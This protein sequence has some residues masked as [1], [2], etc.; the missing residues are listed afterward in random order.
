M[1]NIF[2]YSIDPKDI[3]KAFSNIPLG[4]D[5]TFNNRRLG[6]GFGVS[7]IFYFLI[8]FF[9]PRPAPVGEYQLTE[10]SYFDQ[11]YPPKAQP[12]IPKAGIFQPV[13]L[14]QEKSLAPIDL[15]RRMEKSQASINLDRY[16]KAPTG[17]TEVIKVGRKTGLSTEE[18]LAQAPIELRRAA[19]GGKGQLGLVGYPGMGAGVPL[20]LSS[21]GPPLPR[22]APQV[23]G[24]KA[25]PTIAPTPSKEQAKMKMGANLKKHLIRSSIV[26]PEF[27]NWARKRGLTNV[28]IR[29][30]LYVAAS[31]NIRATIVE[32]SS[33]FPQ[34]DKAVQRTVKRWRCE[35]TVA[36]WNDWVEFL[37]ILR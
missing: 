33:G 24:K 4:L 7:F 16:S 27:P 32:T 17:L 3:P 18:I 2:H 5:N 13:A 31:G 6:I 19:A 10:V 30:R 8:F 37:F 36:E 15:T 12:I 11:S 25:A 21:G 23:T 1:S 26:R 9:W 28:L 35:Q 22:S 20:D 34:W 29:L 14:P